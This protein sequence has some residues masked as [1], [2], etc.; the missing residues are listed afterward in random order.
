[1]RPGAQFRTRCPLSLAGRSSTTCDE[2]CCRS[3]SLACLRQDGPYCQALR[4]SGRCSPS[5]CLPSRPTCRWPVRWGA[6]CAACAFATTL[7]PSTT[8]SSR[9]RASPFCR[10]HSWRIRAWL[11]ADA[12]GRTLWRLLVSGRR[13]LEWV[14]A[15]QVARV[16]PS[17]VQV[18]RQMWAAPAVAIAVAVLVSVAISRATSAR[19][20]D[21]R[22]L[23]GLATDRIRDGPAR[24]AHATGSGSGGARS[25]AKG[26]A[27]DVAILRGPRRA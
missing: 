12:I 15:Y 2:A 9:A 5:L 13:R 25:L 21:H 17:A 8:L 22:A 14:S 3:R 26:C 19:A 18:A 11:M 4:S 27:Q 23:D 1:M 16:D 7:L 20:P 24:I 10:R 6:A